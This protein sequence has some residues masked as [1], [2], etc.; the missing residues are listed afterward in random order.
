MTQ[1][2]ASL[3]AG[4]SS[5]PF[6]CFETDATWNASG[7]STARLRGEIDLRAGRAR[8]RCAACGE[9]ERSIESGAG[10]GDVGAKT[11]WL[12]DGLLAAVGL[13][14]P[15]IVAHRVVHGGL[16][17]GRLRHPPPGERPARGFRDHRRHARP[18]RPR[19]ARA[20]DAVDRFIASVVRHV[21][22]AAASIGGMRALL[23]TGGTDAHQSALRAAAVRRRAWLVSGRAGRVGVLALPTDEEA[24][25]APQ[26]EHVCAPA[27]AS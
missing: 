11:A 12:L 26:V 20:R 13:R 16:K 18:G 17:Y 23:F 19:G 9:A 3:N 24:V 10:R 4:S 7:P 6:A 21:G 27:L 8:L 5:L 25:M 15:D 14:A 22:A 1:A 2:V